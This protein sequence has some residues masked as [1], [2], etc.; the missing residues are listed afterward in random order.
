METG[1]NLLETEKNELPLITTAN[2]ARP[3]GHR[4][5][6]PFKNNC[7]ALLNHTFTNLTLRFVVFNSGFTLSSGVGVLKTLTFGSQVGHTRWY[8][9]TSFLHHFNAQPG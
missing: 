8:I 2:F 4:K 1:G 7:V 3:G 5:F 6:T 9:L